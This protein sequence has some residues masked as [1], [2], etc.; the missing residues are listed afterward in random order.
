MKGK[1]EFGFDQRQDEGMKNCS[2]VEGKMQM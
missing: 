2:R 1:K